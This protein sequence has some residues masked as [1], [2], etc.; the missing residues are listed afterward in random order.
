[1]TVTWRT[2]EVPVSSSILHGN[3][4]SNLFTP[5]KVGLTG[6]QRVDI[7]GAVCNRTYNPRWLLNPEIQLSQKVDLYGA[8]EYQ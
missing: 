3:T 8:V 5:E 2:I 1:M 4:Q 7:V 6:I